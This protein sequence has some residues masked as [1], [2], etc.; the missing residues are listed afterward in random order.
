VKQKVQPYALGAALIAVLFLVQM[1]VLPKRQDIDDLKEAINALNI[2]LVETRGDLERFVAVYE[3][4]E[5]R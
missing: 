1:G 4:R 2:E 3:A 5:G